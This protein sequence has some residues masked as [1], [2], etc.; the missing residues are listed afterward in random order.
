MTYEEPL[1]QGPKARAAVPKVIDMH[2][3]SGAPDADALL[4]GRHERQVEMARMAE[5]SG[6]AS[7]AHNG[8]VML[9]A[10][11]A[12]MAN[13]EKRLEDLDWMGIDLQVVAPSPILY[14]DWADAALA[15]DVVGA[16]NDAASA[17]VARAPDRLAGMGIVALQHP[18]LAATQLKAAHSAGLKGIEISASVAGHGLD[19]PSLDP[20]WA[21]A[22]E[23]P[24]PVFIHPL[25]TSLGVRLDKYYLSNTIGQPI[26]TTI[27]LSQMIFGGVFD[28][29]PDLRVVAAHGGGYLPACIGRSDH[30]WRVRPE[31]RTCKELPSTYLRRIWFDTV[32]FDSAQLTALVARVGADRVMFGTDYPFDMSD[33]DPA[34]VAKALNES[35]H[36]P[37]MGGTAADLFGL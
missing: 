9:P 15:S 25:G 21:A 19:D 31:A 3:H 30:T 2:G 4:A 1:P 36:A 29:F 24:M 34:A 7:M 35:Y 20:F 14:A 18:E 23:T 37:V 17:L 6:A 33:C 12:R 11:G 27:G 13:L 26:E 10:A 5:G 28:R 32:V 22:N 8:Q 16:A